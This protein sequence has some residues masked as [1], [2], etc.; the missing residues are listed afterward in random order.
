MPHHWCQWEESCPSVGVSVRNYV[1]TKASKGPHLTPG[2][3]FGDSGLQ[4]VALCLSF[5]GPW[6]T[7][8]STD[9]NNGA[10]FLQLTPTMGHQP[11]HDFQQWG[12]VYS[13]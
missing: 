10:A 12:K 6:G 8:L 5:S 7:I 4:T 13:H 11:S 3:R 9:T 1:W 2:L